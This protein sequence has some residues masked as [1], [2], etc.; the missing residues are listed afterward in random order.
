MEGSSG[1]EHPAL[2]EAYTLN[3]SFEH[4]STLL[5]V[6]IKTVNVRVGKMYIRKILKK[7]R[8]KWRVTLPAFPLMKLTEEE[9]N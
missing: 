6:S 7:K 2:Q 3:V 5:G 1:E 9:L 4:V 8:T